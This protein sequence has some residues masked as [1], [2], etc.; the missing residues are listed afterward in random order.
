MWVKFPVYQ[1]ELGLNAV[2]TRKGL[3]VMRERGVGER[4]RNRDRETGRDYV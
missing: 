3:F 2:G 4:Q 1:Q